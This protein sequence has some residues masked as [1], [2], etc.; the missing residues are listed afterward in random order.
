MIC[1]NEG[2]VRD[3]T[4]R[5][6]IVPAGPAEQLFGQIIEQNVESSNFKILTVVVAHGMKGK[7]IIEICANFLA[8]QIGGSRRTW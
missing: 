2:S 6:W 4:G 3:C 5:Q 1:L 8:K 7:E